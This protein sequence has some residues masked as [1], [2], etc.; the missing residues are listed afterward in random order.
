M[1]EPIKAHVDQVLDG[2]CVMNMHVTER[3]EALWL[4]YAASVAYAAV[5]TTGDNQPAPLLR[6]PSSALG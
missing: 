4:P 1:N 2:I 3:I 5:C 6:G